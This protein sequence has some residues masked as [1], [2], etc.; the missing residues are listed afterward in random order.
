MK[1][2]SRSPERT[3]RGISQPARSSARRDAFIEAGIRVFGSGGYRAGTV[4][5]LCAEAGL[6]DRY[7]YQSFRNTEDLLIAVYRK[8]MSDLRWKMMQGL[9]AAEPTWDDIADTGLEIYF[10]AVRDRHFARITLVEVLSVSESVRNA[11]HETLEEFAA[12]LLN[13][14]SFL[15]PKHTIPQRDQ[16]LLGIALAGAVMVSGMHWMKS[17]YAVPLHKMVD[18]CRRILVGTAR[19]TLDG[20]R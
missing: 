12:L 8:L 19:A 16:E 3:Y 7:F 1:K 14:F 4:K 15:E 6:T 13:T 20:S 11:Y 5:A 10:E 9:A 2:T 17:G 18:N